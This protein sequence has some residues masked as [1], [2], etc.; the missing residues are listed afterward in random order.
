H[1]IVVR[2]E[3]IP[4]PEPPTSDGTP[5]A[6]PWPTA[7][8]ASAAAPAAD[9]GSTSAGSAASSEPSTGGDDAKKH[10]SAAQILDGVDDDEIG[11]VF[12]SALTESD[13]QAPGA[14]T[15]TPQA[16]TGT[17]AV[18][19]TPSGEFSPSTLSNIP[20]SVTPA[21]VYDW[22]VAID[23]QQVGPITQEKVK[24]LWDSG[25]IGP[26]S[27][28]WRAG[29]ADWKPL[30]GVTELS[31]LLVPTPTKPVIIAPAAPA[32]PAAPVESVFSTSPKTG[33]KEVP[34][35]AAAASA[36]ASGGGGPSAPATLA[37]LLQEEMKVLNTPAPMPAAVP[38]AAQAARPITASSP[39]MQAPAFDAPMGAVP[40]PRFGAY[41]EARSKKG[42]IVAG[43]AGG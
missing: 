6:A 1:V 38:Q 8:V 22:F 12:E 32:T 2:R 33:S 23:D 35:P 11:A 41:A 4:P 42:L 10:L 17:Q 15:P 30:S 3:E 43:V 21:A 26:D 31:S 36:P 20:A 16:T 28:C 24:Q 18:P 34:A 25:E 13:A 39:L 5:A 14:S 29:L 7:G 27:L 9:P 19:A 40:M 37:S